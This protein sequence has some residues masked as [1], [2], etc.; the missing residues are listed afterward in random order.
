MSMSNRIRGAAAF[1]VAMGASS[2]GG[3][4][5]KATRDTVDV[6]P[7]SRVIDFSKHA[8]STSRT[9]QFRI[10]NGQTTPMPV[11]LWKFAFS[12]TGGRPL[13]HVRSE[14]EQPSAGPPG[15]PP[16]YVVLDRKTLALRGLHMGAAPGPHA[17][18][19]VVGN[20]IKGEMP[21]PGRLDTVNITLPN[22]PFYGPLIDLVFESLPHKPGVVYRVPMWRPGAPGN[23]V[24]LYETVRR[25]DVDVLGATHRQAAVIEERS[26]DGSKLLS[27]AWLIDKP[28]FLVRW[29][30]NRPDGSTLRMDQEE[31]KK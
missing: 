11:V 27:T 16:V 18:L 14:P 29:N 2:L 9:A 30:I 3:Q 28:P 1:L 12:D 5:P 13:V 22:P 24:R 7:G 4:A 17:D 15:A 10:A 6:T 21:G 8:P 31:A 25:E 19:T 26:A 23:E 20:T